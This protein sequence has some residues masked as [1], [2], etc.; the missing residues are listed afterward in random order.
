MAGGSTLFFSA[1]LG[2]VACQSEGEPC[3]RKAAGPQLEPNASLLSSRPH[4]CVSAE[5]GEHRSEH[6]IAVFMRKAFLAASAL[7][8]I[9]LLR[10][11]VPLFVSWNVTFRCN[12]RCAYCAACEVDREELG[13]EQVLRGLD[14]LWK[15]G[16]RWV[17]FGGG[18]PLIREDCGEILRYAR[19][20]GFQV[21]LSTN[22][23]PCRKRPICCSMLS[24]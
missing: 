1:V 8:K 16:T 23:I 17:T 7:V 15:V 20:K 19:E 2:E 12:L 10:Q 11:R 4:S 3:L 21:Y 9:H 6:G 22:G 18:E 14:G 13:T 5:R 24:M